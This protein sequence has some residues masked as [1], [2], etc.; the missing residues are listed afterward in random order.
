MWLC[1]EA[2]RGGA[3]PRP[4]GPTLSLMAPPC[5]PRAPPPTGG[6]AKPP[7]LG[8]VAGLPHGAG[9]GSGLFL[10]GLLPPTF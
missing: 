2:K 10:T 9:T 4:H 1:P 6:A 8:G 3:R 7:G 5:P